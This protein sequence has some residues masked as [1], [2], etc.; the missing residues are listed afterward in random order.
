[1]P[2]KYTK[3][4]VVTVDTQE[5]LVRLMRSVACPIDANNDN[6]LE[7]AGPTVPPAHLPSHLWNAFRPVLNPNNQM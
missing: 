6:N 7:D 1:M 3:C 4:M 5:W 2:Y